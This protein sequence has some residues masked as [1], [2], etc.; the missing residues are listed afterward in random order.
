[1]D[2]RT[3]TASYAVCRRITQRYARTFYFASQVLGPRLR[4]AAYAVYAFCR[5]ADD[6]VDRAKAG[7]E[8][9]WVQRE[10]DELQRVVAALSTTEE[11]SLVRFPWYPALRQ[12]VR[13]FG[14]PPSLLAKLLEGVRMDLEKSRYATFQEL[15]QYCYRVASVVGL[16]MC[17]VFGY[18]DQAALGY[19]VDM[20]IAMQLTNILR[21]VAEDYRLGR[22]YLPQEELRAFGYTE[23]ELARGVINDAFRALMAFQVERARR[24]YQRAWEGVALLE[25]RQGRVCTRIMGRLYAGILDEIER[26]S[27]DVFHRRAHV[28]PLRKVVL[29][30]QAALKL[31]A[32]AWEGSLWE[33]P[34]TGAWD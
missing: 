32:K 16:M 31:P 11:L 12:T 9:H 21:D 14:V 3:L 29:G 22:V 1:M 28:G 13:D 4:S 20:G 33:T 18:R 19:A 6:L 5:V 34:A 17:H 2:P 30:A 7:A 15:A 10:L 25:S 24:Y 8:A 23:Q 27:Y 26:A